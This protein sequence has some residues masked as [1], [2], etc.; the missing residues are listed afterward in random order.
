[1]IYKFKTEGRSLRDFNGY[2]N[3]IELFE[4]SR[5]SNV[6]PKNPKEV[7]KNQMN[8]KSGLSKPRKGKNKS[9]Y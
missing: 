4:N 5:D 9:E 7:L 2:Q 1:M 3:L 6:N 8:F